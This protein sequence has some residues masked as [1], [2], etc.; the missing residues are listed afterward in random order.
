MRTFGEAAEQSDAIHDAILR[1]AGRV[2]AQYDKAQKTGSPYDLVDATLAGETKKAIAA[3][4][5]G[6]ITFHVRVPDE[7]DVRRDALVRPIAHRRL[8]RFLGE[9]D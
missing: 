7:F 2:L 6:R 4:P 8:P 3:P 9:R 1:H 5:N